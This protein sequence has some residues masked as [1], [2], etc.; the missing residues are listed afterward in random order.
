M[1][2]CHRPIAID[3]FHQIWFVVNI[4]IICCVHTA[5]LDTIATDWSVFVFY[6]KSQIWYFCGNDTNEKKKNV[7]GCQHKHSNPI[8]FGFDTFSGSKWPNDANNYLKCVSPPLKLTPHPDV[9]N[10]N[11]LKICES[12]SWRC[13]K[14]KWAEISIFVECIR[15]RVVHWKPLKIAKSSFY[16]WAENKTKWIKFNQIKWT[17]NGTYGRRSK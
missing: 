12:S 9:A 4:Q 5:Q 3:E 13:S 7:A 10:Q 2:D 8:R 11:Q 6:T 1:N 14:S 15:R 16:I 17:K